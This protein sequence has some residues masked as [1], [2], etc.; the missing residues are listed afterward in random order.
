MFFIYR[1]PKYFCIIKNNLF[2][3]VIKWLVNIFKRASFFIFLQVAFNWYDSI[4]IKIY[5]LKPLTNFYYLISN[6]NITSK[7]GTLSFY[8]NMNYFIN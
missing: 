1:L 5:F 7:C 4:F 3:R 6:T 8:R 2:F